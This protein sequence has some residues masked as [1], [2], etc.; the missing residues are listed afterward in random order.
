MASTSTHRPCPCSATAR[1]LPSET[2]PP[3]PAAGVII[4]TKNEGRYLGWCLR[5]LH[6]QQF[7][8][9]E[10]IVVDSG[11]TDDT[12]EIARQFPV[13]IL[14]IP[15]E[16]FTYGYALNVGIAATS[17]SIVVSLSGHSIPASDR[18]LG[19][20][21]HHFDDPRIAGA[22]SR[23]RCHRPCPIYERLFVFCFAGHPVRVP[24]LSD[25]LFTNAAS[26]IRRELW[27]RVP[28]DETLPA[29]E[30]IAWRLQA[31]D[32]GYTVR[33]APDSIVI[34]SHAETFARFMR[35]RLNECRGLARVYG[36]RGRAAT[37]VS[38]TMRCCRDWLMLAYLAQWYVQRW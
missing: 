1:S 7:T 5:E 2:T 36:A 15:P 6:R 12:L 26:A 10:V 29:C 21:L 24:W 18:W 19:N 28:F 4:R 20:L 3:A 14:T 11:S 38:P 33:Y 23:Q 35:R 34:H 30:D 22:F 32:H 13:Q 16:S 25:H 37:A 9:F 31:L 27:E 8:D 17:A